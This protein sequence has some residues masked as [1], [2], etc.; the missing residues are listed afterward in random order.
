MR[1]VR[2][3]ARQVGVSVSLYVLRFRGL[4]PGLALVDLNLLLG[5]GGFT[6]DFPPVLLLGAFFALVCLGAM[7]RSFVTL[8]DIAA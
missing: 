3:N 5:G 6:F 8:F 1:L 2:P 7:V 4:R